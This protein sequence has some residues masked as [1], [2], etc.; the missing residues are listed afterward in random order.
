MSLNKEPSVVVIGYGNVGYHIARALLLQQYPLLGVYSRHATRFVDQP[1]LPPNQQFTD[2]GE[3]PIAEVYI[4]AVADDQIS[5]ASQQLAQSIPATAQQALVVHTSGSVPATAL[6]Q[7]HKR[8]GVFYPLQTFTLQQ[9]PTWEHLPLCLFA[10][11]PAD[12]LLLQHIAGYLS[13]RVYI[14][15]DQQRAWLHVAA[16]FSNNFTNY[17]FSLAEQICQSH[18]LPFELLLPLITATAEKVQHYPPQQLQT[19]PARRHDHETIERHLTMLHD[20]PEYK[21][22]YTLLSSQIEEKYKE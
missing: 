8:Y 14:L 9:L 2:M 11:F 7:N 20:M 10:L 1:L 12:L 4:L 16:V 21:A 18:Q 13:P 15:N 17:M 22:I 5:N 6:A 3:L 19:G